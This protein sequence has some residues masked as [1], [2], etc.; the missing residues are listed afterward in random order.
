MYLG[1]TS[2][3]FR[4]S[5]THDMGELPHPLSEPELIYQIKKA[6]EGDAHAIK[7]IAMSHMRL[8]MQIASAYANRYPKRKGD[9]ISAMYHGIMDA[10]SR[11]YK[12]RD[13]GVSA[14][15]TT[16]IHGS[17]STFLNVDHLIRIPRS[18]VQELK[19]FPYAV[20]IAA[21]I[22]TDNT[23]YSNDAEASLLPTITDDNSLDVIDFINQLPVHC[24]RVIKLRMENYHDSE[25]ALKMGLSKARIGQI[26]KEVAMK[27]QRHGQK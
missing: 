8:G 10:L 21:K 6:K 25:I 14:W 26:R 4:Y 3:R 16:H 17:I 5:I 11:I 12:L 27:W 24:G 20:T 15:I 19:M 22:D 13:N 9:I 23:E 2:Q 18:R 7:I 1:H